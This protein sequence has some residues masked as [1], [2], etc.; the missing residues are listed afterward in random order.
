MTQT[1]RATST[2]ALLA[3]CLLAS[4]EEAPHTWRSRPATPARMAERL[5]QAADLAAAQ[6]PVS[7]V[8]L[9]DIAYPYNEGEYDRLG[10]N[11]I[12]LITALT[13]QRAEL[14]LKRVYVVDQN[15]AVELRELKA[16][17]S[18]PGERSAKAVKVFGPYRSD[19]LYLL[20]IRLRLKPSELYVEFGG[21]LSNVRVAT[22]GGPASPAVATVLSRVT[23]DPSLAEEFVREF[24]QREYPG[25][26]D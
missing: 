7:F 9:Y 22:F 12:L 6:A 18:G 3:C 24:T 23:R 15:R 1:I 10:G 26:F 21:A 4:A 14:P 19:G 16:V 20:P 5:A 11:A 13:Q 2:A 8:A 17:L 25:F